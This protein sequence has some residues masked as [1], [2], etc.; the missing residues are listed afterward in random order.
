[1]PLLVPAQPVPHAPDHLPPTMVFALMVHPVSSCRRAVAAVLPDLPLPLLD[2]PPAVRRH[3]AAGAYIVIFLPRFS[4][5]CC[6]HTT[7]TTPAAAAAP[8]AHHPTAC[9]RAALPRTRTRTHHPHAPHALLYTHD[10]PRAAAA[11]RFP[12]TGRAAFCGHMT[13]TLPCGRP[14]AATPRALTFAFWSI[15]LDRS[16]VPV[17]IARIVNW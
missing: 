15:Q 10:T 14:P 6:L 5:C 13:P 9:C 12:P 4:R 16:A 11:P 7:T 17:H 3:L 8:H 1:M 2:L